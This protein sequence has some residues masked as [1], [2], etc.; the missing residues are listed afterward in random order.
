M[1]IK[2]IAF[3]IATDILG[4]RQLTVEFTDQT[5]DIAGLKTY[6]IEQ[7]PAFADLASLRFAVGE[8]YQSDDFLLKADMEV[9]VI[10]PVAGG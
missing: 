5:Q 7:Y 4:Q 3:G 10:P 2:I 1:T 6:L 9:V 8:A